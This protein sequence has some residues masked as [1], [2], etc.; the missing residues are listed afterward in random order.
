[1]FEPTDIG[2]CSDF[3]WLESKLEGPSSDAYLIASGAVVVQW[4]DDQ[5]VAEYG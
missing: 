1:M 3:W 5:T 2:F 4:F